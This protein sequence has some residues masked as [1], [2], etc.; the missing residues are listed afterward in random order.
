MISRFSIKTD[1]LSFT[2]LY[3]NRNIAHAHKKQNT[4]KETWINIISDAKM[5]AFFS[6]AI[7]THRNRSAKYLS[8]VIYSIYNDLIIFIRLFFIFSMSCALV[9]DFNNE[10]PRLWLL[11]EIY[12]SL[13][14]LHFSPSAYFTIRSSEFIT[15]CLVWR[16]KGEIKNF[17]L[18]SILFVFFLHCFVLEA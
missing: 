18:F 5:W 3:T 11:C 15:L 17:P 9:S 6:N 4:T 10:K 1:H 14:F 12:H 2:F 8:L 13:Q 16:Q 7:S